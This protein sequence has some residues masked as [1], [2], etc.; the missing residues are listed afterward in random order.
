MSQMTIVMLSL[1]MILAVSASML[2]GGAFL[3]FTFKTRA[4]SSD[5]TAGSINVVLSAILMVSLLRQ[6]QVKDTFADHAIEFLAALGS[7]FFLP[8]ILLALI[9]LTGAM[10]WVFQR[11]DE[12]Q[13]RAQ[14]NRRK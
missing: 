13:E 3:R 10:I 12:L 9:G 7:S 2:V 14:A 6:L 8:V 1:D 11:F 5:I 4:L